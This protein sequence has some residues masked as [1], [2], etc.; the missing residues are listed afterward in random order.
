VLADILESVM[1]FENAQMIAGGAVIIWELMCPSSI[2]KSCTD[3]PKLPES[4]MKNW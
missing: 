1:L 3:K 4:T 2:V